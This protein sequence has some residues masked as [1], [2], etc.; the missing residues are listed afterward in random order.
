M[1]AAMEWLPGVEWAKYG[2]Q[3]LI[4]T[5]EWYETKA[6]VRVLE[7]NL[8]IRDHF[9]KIVALMKHGRHQRLELLLDWKQDIRFVA[10]IHSTKLGHPAG[11]IRRH[12]LDDSELDVIAD[13]LNLGR[14][15]SFKNAAASIPNGGCKFGVHSSLPEEER[16][17]GFYGF[18]AFCIDR[19]LAFT[20]PD[21][22]FSLE[23]ANRIRKFTKNIVGGTQKTGSGGAT[24]VTAAWGVFV[25]MKQALADAGIEKLDGASV[26][27]QGVGELGRPLVEHL[28]EAGARVLAADT[29]DA[30]LEA[31]PDV[32]T[33][34]S[35][36]S[37]LRTQCDVLAPC[38]VG[39]ILDG[40]AID[41]LRCKLIVGGA[42]NQLASSSEM[43]EYLMAKRI[44]DRGILFVP[45]W[46]VNAGGVIQ[47]KMEHVKGPEF[48][49]DEALSAAEGTIP[50][51]VKHVL[52]IARREGITPTE[53][54]YRKFN[55][56]V[57][58]SVD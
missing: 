58:G 19:N 44:A 29:S 55:Y 35:A 20:G 25:A 3:D 5:M 33:R 23:D 38:A 27:V 30:A 39:G 50:Q 48:D 16:D 11:G 2:D 42:N 57:Y 18:L 41:E 7:E 21:M 14:G 40:Q 9:D 13:I 56:T 36:G 53:A 8:T 24:G 4:S 51:N 28:V 1:R 31:L 12:P 43:D 15:M 6:V 47:G 37:I 22:G 49:L 34:G 46:I 17:D 52:A 54:A 10:G 45:D 32:V 26:A